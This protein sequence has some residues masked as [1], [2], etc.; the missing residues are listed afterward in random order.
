M[1]DPA[2]RSARGA[3]NK[4]KILAEAGSDSAPSAPKTVYEASWRDFIFAEVWERPGLDLRARY[5]IS[6]ASAARADTPSELLDGYIA[7]ALQQQQLS[8]IELRE[9][10]LHLAIYGGWSRG[11]VLDAAISRVAEKAGLESSFEP[12]RAEAWDAGQRLQDGSESFKRVMTFDGPPPVSAYFETGILNFVFAEA[13]DRPGLDQRGR[14]WIT[15]VGVADSSA[16]IP[17]R[18]HI[19]GAMASGNA[20]YQEMDEFVLQYA[21]HS[22][23]PKASFV[24]SVVFEMAEKLKNNLSW[25]GKPLGNNSETNDA[26]SE[27]Q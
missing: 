4:A 24:Q 8:L 5:L 19:Y 14:R 23:W 12:I 22:G 7:G 13:W 17:I 18:T 15:L 10:A 16:D 25:D 11:A 21:I 27:E 20:S 6:L 9:A 3:A 1:L 2:E 26:K